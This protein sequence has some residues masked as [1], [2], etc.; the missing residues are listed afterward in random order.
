MQYLWVNGADQGMNTY[1]RVPPTNNP[2]TDVTS[3]DIRC[4]QPLRIH[5]CPIALNIQLYGVTGNVN[6][7][8]GSTT[9]TKP[10]VAAGSN[11]TLEWHQH[12]A[13]TGE[14]PISGGHKGP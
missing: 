6:G 2:V 1:L 12:A 8:T 3:T 14:D 4:K 7:L 13:R 9:G 11:I 10:S 5:S